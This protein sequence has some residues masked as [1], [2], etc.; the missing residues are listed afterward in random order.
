MRYGIANPGGQVPR[1]EVARILDTARRL[2]LGVLDTAFEY[3]NAEEVLG[4]ALHPADEFRLVTKTPR[5]RAGRVSDADA[6]SLRAS[7]LTSLARLQRPCV[8][9]LLVH[10]PADLL[11]P[12]G[13]RLYAE[14]TALKHGGLACKV[15]ASVYTRQQLDAIMDRFPLDLVQVP[16][17]V[18]DQRLVTSGHLARLKASG[19]EV[20]ARSAFLQGLLLMNPARLEERFSSVRDHL[21]RYHAFLAHAG[22]DPVQA[23]IGF[24]I[25]LPQ[26]DHAVVGVLQAEQLEQ[27]ADAAASPVLP[28][29]QMAGFAWDDE[30]ILDPTLW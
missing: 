6:E 4:E 13:D 19:V 30:A 9:G 17:N 29:D 20:H 26:V 14:L 16:V 28:A 21:S 23:A 10:H 11:V 2:R 7:F 25:S 22:I 27:V 8:Y 12:G 18:L 15:G 5:L 24:V 3:G 1:R